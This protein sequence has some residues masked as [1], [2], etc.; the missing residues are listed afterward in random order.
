MKSLIA[1]PL[2]IKMT[3]FAISQC[4]GNSHNIHTAAF[5]ATNEA[6]L[7]LAQDY[8]AIEQPGQLYTVKL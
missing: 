4:L 8:G 3:D 1:R 2:A 5:N 6:M 7:R